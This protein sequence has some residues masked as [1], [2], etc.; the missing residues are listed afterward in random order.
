MT[1]L[2]GLSA[3]VSAQRSQPA[4]ACKADDQPCQAIDRLEVEWNMINELSD[5][6]GKRRMLAFDSYHVGPSGRLYDKPADI[7]A[8]KLANE[9]QSQYAEVRFFIA[10]KRIRVYGEVAVV[11]ASGS[12]IT[13]NGG[14][15]SAGR[16][17]RFVHVWEKR[18][19]IWYLAVDQVTAVEN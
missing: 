12:S 10:G 5:P 13:T 3:A 15:K 16:P 11:T 4:P 6:E 18:E 1:I 14:C 9:R 17:F 2:L 19:G 8:A 7:A